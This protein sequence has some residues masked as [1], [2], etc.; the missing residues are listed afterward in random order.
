MTVSDTSDAGTR[1]R[2]R[3]VSD[4][5]RIHLTKS[6][7]ALQVS[8]AQQKTQDAIVAFVNAVR[9]AGQTSQF[10]EETLTAPVR[11][12]IGA[13]SAAADFKPVVIADKATVKF[14]DTS[15]GIPDLSVYRGG[16]LLLVIEL[17]APGRGANPTQFGGREKDQWERYSQLPTVIY[18]DGNDWTLW[19]SGSPGATLSVCDNLMDPAS[20]VKV[21][22]AEAVRL[23]SDALDAPP[24]TITS[25]AQLARE[26]ARRCRALRD[27]VN[28]LDKSL[29]KEMTQD[30]RDI[31]F[32]DLADDGFVDAYAQTVAFALLAAGSSGIELSLDVDPSRYDR[33]GLLV[34][35]V[36]ESLGA[37]RGVLGK[38]LD[39]LTADP[40]VRST[41]STSLDAMVALADAVEWSSI[42]GG[43]PSD[44]WMDFYETFL[45][46]YDPVLKKQSGSYYTPQAVVKWMT[47]FTDQILRDLFGLSD[48]YADHR[49]K[50]VDPALG[51]GTY[52]LSI[53]DRI[54]STVSSRVGAGQAAAQMNDALTHRVFG[55]EIQ[56]C[57]YAVAQLR[58]IE[59]IRA[60]DPNITDIVPSVY[61]NDTLADPDANTGQQMFF[62]KAIT[63]SREQAD[64]IKRE[65]PIKVVI[66]NPP[67]L[68]GASQSSWVSR[69]MLDDWQPDQAWGVS[70]HAK[71]L[72]NLYVYFWRWAAWKVLENSNSDESEQAGIVSFITPTGW[73]EGDGF[74]QMRRWLREWCS[75]IWVLDL[76]PE[77]HQA[78]AKSQV[79]EAMRQPVAI[80]TV[81][82]VPE[83]TNTVEVRHHRVPTATRQ[84]KFDYIA[85]LSAPDDTRWTLLQAGTLGDRDRMTP[86]A[87]QAWQKMPSIKELLPWHASGMMI[88]RTW[89]VA[90]DW[91]VL[92]DRWNTL[93][94]QPNHDEMTRHLVEHKRDRNIRTDLIDNLTATCPRPGPLTKQ[95]PAAAVV[96]EYGYRSFD[97]Q[98]VIR[99]KRLI[100][101][102]N[103]SLWAAHSDTQIHLAAP[104]LGTASTRPVI[105]ASTGQIISFTAHIPDMH[106]LAGSRAG[107]IHPLWRDP[108]ETPNTDQSTL[109]YMTS[110]FG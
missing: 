85:R 31:L 78:P 25:T 33:L 102:P 3:D 43:S 16:L 97:R 65:T 81:A 11:E 19:R 32:P 73:L 47:R 60:L 94:N 76:S 28:S 27:D 42:R 109:N 83:Q 44:A 38:A 14:G 30:W 70:T 53:L 23:F 100:N 75:H 74:Q 36:S 51:T 72:S 12:L 24:L 56:A 61:L 20:P 108:S 99:D 5:G 6:Q 15:V 79:F 10:N 39:L 45:G 50:V 55:F 62:M 89:P 88:G 101:R 57:P 54:A 77:G 9:T 18:T 87:S 22:G 105:A 35:H 67:Y 21:C 95:T 69:T 71:N 91:H 80:V 103:P 1:S 8:E 107:R 7:R 26:T 66:G 46:E 59:S 48:G 34:H 92:Q 2:T 4:A 98:Y 96:V 37:E 58:L 84:S 63:D 41:V 17:K 13:M 40:V 49:V 68:A 86:V 104:D 52:L 90:P 93:L 64:K 29:L 110:V 82:R 106:H